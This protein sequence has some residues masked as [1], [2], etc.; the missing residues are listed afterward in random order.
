MS[1]H[2]RG[3]RGGPGPTGACPRL[4]IPF[5]TQSGETAS[6][7]PSPLGP[8]VSSPSPFKTGLAHYE[9]EKSLPRR[10]TAAGV[11]LACQLPFGPGK[12]RCLSPVVFFPASSSVSASF[13]RF[14]LCRPMLS[15]SFVHFNPSRPRRIASATW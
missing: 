11:K 3:L 9:Q 5:I 12:G 15:T 13:F 14:F 8:G 4:L 10:R 6:S 1:A 7:S 2:Y